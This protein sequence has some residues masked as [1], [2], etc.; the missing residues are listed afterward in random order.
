MAARDRW[1][2]TLT[3]PNCGQSG[4]AK[5]SEDDYPFMKSPGFWFDELPDGFKGGH[6][7]NDTKAGTYIICRCGT[8]FNYFG[9][10]R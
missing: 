4:V 1:T 6:S 7:K 2:T 3:C 10:V 8:E 5:C 9:D